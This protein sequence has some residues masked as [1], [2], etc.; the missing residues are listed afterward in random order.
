MIEL[1]T[2]LT[3]SSCVSQLTDFYTSNMLEAIIEHGMDEITVYLCDNDGV[4]LPYKLHLKP[5]GSRLEFFEVT[6]LQAF[7]LIAEQVVGD[8]YWQPAYHTRIAKNAMKTS[9]LFKCALHVCGDYIKFNE[10]GI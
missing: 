8:I 4:Q 9:N 1:T 7:V 3:L 5:E 2:R 6:H 10:K